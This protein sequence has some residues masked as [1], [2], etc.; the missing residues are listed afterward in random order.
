M[1]LQLSV[2]AQPTAR[3]HLTDFAD[4]G[5]RLIGPGDPAFAP[6][7]AA[8]VR[9]L[10]QSTTHGNPRQELN[11]GPIEPLT[12]VLMND[13]STAIVGY[14]IVWIG[15]DAMGQA[16][17][18]PRIYMQ[19]YAL[20][21]GFALGYDVK[22]RGGVLPPKGNKVVTPFG[23][24]DDQTSM[25]MS[26]SDQDTAEFV[27]GF[28]GG[29]IEVQLDAVIFDD[30]TVIGPDTTHLMDTFG[31]YLAAKNDVLRYLM[32]PANMMN[33]V[34]SRFELLTKHILTRVHDGRSPEFRNKYEE[35]K[36]QFAFELNN[37]QKLAGDDAV[38]KYVSREY[39]RYVGVQP[40]IRQE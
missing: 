31:A 19:P 14:S 8:T 15:T 18:E 27:A 28:Q 10:E 33:E 21:H 30:G 22:Q 1:T 12:V 34:T 3:M 37:V 40:L 20:K 32:E 16:Q 11:V 24:F 2:F 23:A 17:R 5:V 36:E 7:V 39:P 25:S 35:W 4:Q 29:R 26:L 38:R 6:L 13:S 9:G